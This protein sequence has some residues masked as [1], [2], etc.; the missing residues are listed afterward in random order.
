[1]SGQI[2]L[3]EA[4]RKAF[5]TKYDDGL[6]D[7]F[8]GGI[9]AIFAIAPYLSESMGD[10]WSSLVF[11][12]I[13]ALL[14][15]TILLVR[16]HVV[17]PRVG[18]VKFSQRRKTRMLKFTVVM[19]I[20]N[21]AGLILGLLAARYFGEPPEYIYTIAISLLLLTGFSAAAYYLDVP[22]YYVYGV[23]AW[24]TPLAG[25]WLWNQG[26]AAHHGFPVTFGIL[27][28]IMVLT[29]LVVFIRLLREN[30]LPGGE[31]PSKNANHG[32]PTS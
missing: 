11:L 3:K 4:E 7:V 24:L 22:R 8:M 20:I 26:F 18:A 12:P 29:G 19:M 2:S 27:S 30:P 17:T 31:T 6:L 9:L 5:R 16:K 25:E 23:L 21:A 15:L 32:Q 13:W 28:G 14:Y 10:F 1:M